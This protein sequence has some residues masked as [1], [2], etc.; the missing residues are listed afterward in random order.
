[1]CTIY[2]K[3]VEISRIV[4]ITDVEFGCE[5][6]TNHSQL[7]CATPPLRKLKRN[8]TVNKF[9]ILLPYTRDLLML[10]R[11]TL[12]SNISSDLYTLG[13]NNAVK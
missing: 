11:R 12:V 7:S 9:P 13:I 4:R 2:L 6:S 3:V 8:G 5:L 10:W 1:M